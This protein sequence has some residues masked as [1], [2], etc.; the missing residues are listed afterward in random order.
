MTYSN[1][2]VIGDSPHN[3]I[4]DAKDSGGYGFLCA[5]NYFTIKNITV[6]NAPYTGIRV[7]SD[8]SLIEN[9][10]VYGSGNNGFEASNYCTFK[11]CL[12]YDNGDDGFDDE[13]EC[14]YINC[15]AANNGDEG[16]Y[17]LFGGSKYE[18]CISFGNTGYGFYSNSANSLE[19]IYSNAW[20]NQQDYSNQ[21]QGTGSISVDPKFVDGINNLLSFDKQPVC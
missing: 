18:N 2:T 19:I 12:S 5:Q 1:I 15:T 6:R 8:Y 7:A 10:I 14:T 11:N 13:E 20:D 16:F 21:V 17:S 4:I 9:C 3:T